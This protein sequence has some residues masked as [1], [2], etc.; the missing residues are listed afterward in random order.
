MFRAA[1]SHA[2]SHAWVPGEAIDT[3]PAGWEA[4]RRLLERYRALVPGAA[5]TYAKGHD[6]YPADLA[7]FIVRGHGSHVWDVD[8]NEYVE[9]GSGLRSVTLGHGHPRIVAAATEAMVH[10]TNFVRPARLEVDV[11]EA[12][13][14]NF[15][16]LDMVKFA[17]NGSDVT[18]AAVRLARAATGRDVVAICRDQPFFSTD[19]WFIG[20]TAMP[21]GIPEVTRHLTVPFSYNDLESLRVV[22][23]N[24]RDRV[25]CVVLEAAT[26]VEPEPGFLDGVRR[27]CDESGAIL[28]LDE[29]ITGFRWP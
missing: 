14:G 13:L 23:A 2:G 15:D 20:A 6:Q 11:A 8:G 22:L 28:I 21:A 27:L 26:A 10:G 9:Y 4:S 16:R 25:A 18:T 1:A 12:F 5:H 24:H 3:A 17:K 29:M 19:D 7:P